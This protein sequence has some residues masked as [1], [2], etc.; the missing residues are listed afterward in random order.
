[1][2]FFS[3]LM[4][5]TIYWMFIKNILLNAIFVW[6]DNLWHRSI[7]FAAERMYVGTTNELEVQCSSLYITA[8]DMEKLCRILQLKQAM[9]SFFIQT[10]RKMENWSIVRHCQWYHPP[11]VATDNIAVSHTM[12]ASTKKALRWFVLFSSF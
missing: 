5:V 3:R 4:A 6:F 9:P 10:H 7:W 11:C 2:L 1:M 12:M 8:C